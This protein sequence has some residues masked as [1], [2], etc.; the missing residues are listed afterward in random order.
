VIVV[1]TAV[2]GARVV[3]GCRAE[4]EAVVEKA[5]RRYSAMLKFQVVLEALPGEKSPAQIAK[6]HRVPPTR[7]GF[8]NGGS[9]SGDP[10]CSSRAHCS[11]TP[12]ARRG[13]LEQLL[14]TRKSR[15]FSEIPLGA[16]GLRGRRGG[17]CR[18]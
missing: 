6:T 7:W 8:G 1:L 3:E 12:S 5:T 10:R 9:W 15:S 4:T 16:D 14:A 13:G 17:L 18:A 2:H 11:A